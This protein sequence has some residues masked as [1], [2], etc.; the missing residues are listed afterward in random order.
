[1]F[2]RNELQAAR[3]VIQSKR[4]RI[5]ELHSWVSRG[6]QKLIEA[7]RTHEAATAVQQR[8]IERLNRIVKHLRARPTIAFDLWADNVRLAQEV[9]QLRDELEAMRTTRSLYCNS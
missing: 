3:A 6:T 1:M 7:H 2:Y 8:E 5:T 9:D 4:E